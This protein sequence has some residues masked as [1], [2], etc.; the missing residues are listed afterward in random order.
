MRKNTSAS[1]VCTL[2]RSGAAVTSPAGALGR[3]PWLAVGDRGGG[4]SGATTSSL[5]REL[6]VVVGASTRWDF[7]AQTWAHPGQQGTSDGQWG[8]LEG[9]GGGGGHI[10]LTGAPLATGTTSTLVGT[11]LL[12]WERRPPPGEAP[13]RGVPSAAVTSLLTGGAD[14]GPSPGAALVPAVVLRSA[15]VGPCGGGGAGAAGKEASP[16]R[17]ASS[18][19]QHW[20]RNR[21]PTASTASSKPTTP[22]VASPGS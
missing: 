6:Q 17:Q 20:Y 21:D 7:G 10:Y 8:E 11:I 2:A 22:A 18:A 16:W 4:G 15:V 3:P 14:T 5:R 9:A 1:C 13:P 19:G 12:A